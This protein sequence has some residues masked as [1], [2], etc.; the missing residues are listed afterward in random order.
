MNCSYCNR[1]A[2]YFQRHSGK[3]LCRKHFVEN[4]LKRVKRSIRKY[5]MVRRNER[6][7]VALSGGKDSVVL[8]QVLKTLYGERRDIELHAITVDEGIEGYRPP[9]VEISERLCREL[10]IEHHVVSFRDEIGLELDEIVKKGNRNACSYCGVFRKYLLNKKAKEIGATK[11]ATGHNLDDETQTILLNFLQSDIERMA[12]LVPSRVQKGLVMRIKPLREI[13]ERE[14]VVYA[15]LH[16]LPVSLEECP[17]SREPVRAAVRDFLY[18]FENKYPGRKFSIMRS[19]ETLLP[20]LWE[21]YPQI[22]LNSC[23][24]CG[25]PTPRRIC[26]ACELKRELG[27]I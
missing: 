6:I 16:N 18:E 13:Y 2:V 5:R 7:A 3:H 19:F 1:K 26:Q 11:L 22:D 4:F 10:D 12:R 14:I 20:C 15:L 9:T 17:Y 25:E 21:M 8:A 27:L 23:E 24:L